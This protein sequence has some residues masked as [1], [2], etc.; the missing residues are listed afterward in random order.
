MSGI[1]ISYRREDS[2]GHSGWLFDR[3]R[4]RFGKDHVFMDVSAIEPDVDFVGAID[5]AVGSCDALIVVIGRKWLILFPD[6]NTITLPFPPFALS[7]SK[8]SHCVA[9]GSTSSPRTVKI[10][11]VFIWKWNNCFFW[12]QPIF[13]SLH[14]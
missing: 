4:E 5:S 1:F 12:Y 7:L 13:K 10:I 6:I 9:S 2:A 3:L 11:L 8:G 14:W